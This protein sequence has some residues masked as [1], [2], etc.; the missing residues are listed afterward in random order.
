MAVSVGGCDVLGVGCFSG[1]DRVITSRGGEKQSACWGLV[2]CR[3]S[4]VHLA[5][6]CHLRRKPLSN[7]YL[8]PYRSETKKRNERHPILKC[9]TNPSWCCANSSSI[10][11]TLAA[12]FAGTSRASWIVR[13]GMPCRCSSTSPESTN[14]RDS[15]LVSMVWRHLVPSRRSRTW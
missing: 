2:R 13:A 15:A 12:Y 6:Q 10:R 11:L 14:N 3:R 9:G 5:L 7:S 4:A 1:V 8:Q